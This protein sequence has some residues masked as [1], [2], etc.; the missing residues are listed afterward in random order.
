[1]T[2]FFYTNSYWHKQPQDMNISCR[3]HRVN[4][5]INFLEQQARLLLTPCREEG[6]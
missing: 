2:L 5:S 1:V 6:Q 3:P 4:C